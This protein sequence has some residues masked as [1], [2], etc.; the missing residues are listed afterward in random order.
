M[1]ESMP[2]I[3]HQPTETSPAERISSSSACCIEVS[4]GPPQVL[5]MAARN[6]PAPRSS[7]TMS[8]GSRRSASMRAEFSRRTGTSSRARSR[9]ASAVSGTYGV[10]VVITFSSGVRVGRDGA[11]ALTRSVRRP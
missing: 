6:T 3:A 10:V 11:A 7:S 1:P 4:S 9:I 2:I 8:S 5:G